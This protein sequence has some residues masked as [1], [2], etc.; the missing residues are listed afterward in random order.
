LDWDPNCSSHANGS[1]DEKLIQRLIWDQKIV[2]SILDWVI[3]WHVVMA[4]SF[5][6]DLGIVTILLWTSKLVDRCE[7]LEGKKSWGR[8]LCNIP[9]FMWSRWM[10]FSHG[11]FCGIH[12]WCFPMV[13]SSLLEKN[14]E[15]NSFKESIKP[16]KGERSKEFGSS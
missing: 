14:N 7:L 1:I 13:F 10:V 3:Q 12:P 6:W 11:I 9:F 5:I 4:H 16:I 8:R 2:I 15:L